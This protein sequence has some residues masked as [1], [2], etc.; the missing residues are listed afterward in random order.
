MSS[1]DLNLVPSEPAGGFTALRGRLAGLGGNARQYGIFAALVV[2]I[3]LFEVT[4]HGRLLMPDNV[5]ALFR[6]N[7]A[8][9]ARLEG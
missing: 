5:A 9:K 1:P 3:L 8:L 4:T 2:I 7:A 6:Q